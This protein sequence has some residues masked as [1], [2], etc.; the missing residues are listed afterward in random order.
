MHHSWV[1]S[2]PYPQI[3]DKTGKACQVQVFQCFSNI[4][5]KLSLAGVFGVLDP[6][7]SF[8]PSV[9]SVGKV[10]GLYYKHIMI[11]NDAS[12]VVSE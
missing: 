9:M 11:L 1:G 5:N 10:S 2:S 4:R 3:I 7:K 8:Q 12:R 6:D